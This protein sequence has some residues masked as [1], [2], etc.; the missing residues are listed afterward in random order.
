MYK[1]LILL[2]KTLRT[3]VLILLAAALSLAVIVVLYAQLTL[4]PQKV[5]QTFV[6]E[7]AQYL[8]REVSFGSV[9]ISLFGG[10]RLKDV[11]LRKSFDWEEDD[12]LICPEVTIKIR[13]L[14]LLVKQ[15]VHQGGCFSITR[16]F[17][18]IS[19][20]WASLS[21]SPARSVNALPFPHPR[22]FSLYSVI[23][24]PGHVEVRSGTVMLKSIAREFPQPV[25]VSLDQVRMLISDVSLLFS[26]PFSVTAR[27]NGSDCLSVYCERENICSEKIPD[28]R[29]F[30]R[31]H[32]SC[33]PSG[34]I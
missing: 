10:I 33:N 5:R 19:A 21:A 7:I 11:V 3:I 32:R 27:I 28:G 4:T 17:V 31:Q 30:P 14:P 8:Q 29:Y 18:F 1:T 9:Q 20:T 12:V 26:F 34:T 24:L 6:A 16:R 2:M 23:F 13:L 25:T 22:A 15:A